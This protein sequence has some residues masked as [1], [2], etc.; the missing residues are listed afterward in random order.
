MLQ[1][2]RT[3]LVAAAVAV[4]VWAAAGSAVAQRVEHDVAGT[5]MVMEGAGNPD[6]IG[7]VVTAPAGYDR[8]KRFTYWIKPDAGG[9]TVRPAVRGYNSVSDR[10]AVQVIETGADQSLSGPGAR[11]VTFEFNAPVVAGQKYMLA[12]EVVSGDGEIETVFP[13]SYADGFWQTVFFNGAAAFP[14]TDARFTAEFGHAAAPAAIP[15]MT[16]WAMILMALA[17]AGGAVVL[18]QR[19]RIT[20]G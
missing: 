15:T 7:Q 8:V 4:G 20:A 2:I 10:D 16:E 18:L 19:R 5:M 12:L 6:R 3:G 14:N 13:G 17:M 9:V 11:A 1:K